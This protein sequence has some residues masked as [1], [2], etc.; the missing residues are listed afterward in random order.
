M[1][2]SRVSPSLDLPLRTLITRAINC[3]I[4]LIALIAR[5]IILIVSRVNSGFKAQ[6]VSVDLM[7]LPRCVVILT[8]NELKFVTDFV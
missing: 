5:L 3:L 1:S 6:F 7:M 2:I 8:L 4:A